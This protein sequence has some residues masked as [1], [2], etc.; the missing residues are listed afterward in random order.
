LRVA[1][2]R[3]ICSVLSTCCRNS[4]GTSAYP[5][6]S[7]TRCASAVTRGLPAATSRHRCRQ[8]QRA[9]CRGRQTDRDTARQTGRETERERER[10]RDAVSGATG[11]AY[12][13]DRPTDTPTDRQRGPNCPSVSHGWTAMLGIDRPVPPSLPDRQK[14]DT[15]R[16]TDRQTDR[17]TD[18]REDQRQRQRDALCTSFPSG[19]PTTSGIFHICPFSLDKSTPSHTQSL[20]QPCVRPSTTPS[21]SSSSSSRSSRSSASIVGR[22]GPPEITPK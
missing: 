18:G 14:R 22:N 1:R 6:Y 17:R 19:S 5:R 13:R 8:L 10:E 21:S 15:D 16:Q 4:G 3:S 7:P 9:R 2:G 20:S 11:S 12:A